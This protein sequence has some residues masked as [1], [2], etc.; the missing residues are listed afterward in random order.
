MPTSIRR[1]CTTLRSIR[2]RKSRRA[3]TNRRKWRPRWSGCAPVPG[4][5]LKQRSN[6]I[7]A[8]LHITSANELTI[9]LGDGRHFAVHPLWLRERCLD[10]ETFDL[11]TG[12]R[13]GDPS[14]LDLNL[15]LSAVS[16]PQPG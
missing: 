1:F 5:G 10:P 2:L 16:E 7:M 15:T 13:L 4:P 12:Q 11:R 6:S 8:R 14:D 3:C 9:E